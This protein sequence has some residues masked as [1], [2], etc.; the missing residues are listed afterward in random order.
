MVSID[1][2][3]EGLILELKHSKPVKKTWWG[4]KIKILSINNT[5]HNIRIEAEVLTAPCDL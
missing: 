2:I 1:Q 3:K 5:S 4:H